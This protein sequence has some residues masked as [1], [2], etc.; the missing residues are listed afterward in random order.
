M[1]NLEDLKSAIAD[2]QAAATKQGDVVRSLKA[3]LKEGKIEKVI[4]RLSAGFGLSV[5]ELKE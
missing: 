3:E 4:Q 1:A 2:A 5:L